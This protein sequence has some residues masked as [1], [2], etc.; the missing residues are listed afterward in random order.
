ME[1]DSYIYKHEDCCKDDWEYSI[2]GH[3][4]ADWSTYYICLLDISSKLVCQCSSYLWHLWIICTIIRKLRHLE[5]DLVC[6]WNSLNWDTCFAD[7]CRLCNNRN[8]IWLSLA[9]WVLFVKTYCKACTACKLN[10]E[11]KWWTLWLIVNRH[12]T[13]ACDYHDEWSEHTELACFH[14]VCLLWLS[15]NTEILGICNTEIHKRCEQWLADCQSCKYWENNTDSQCDRKSL[16]STCSEY[17]KYKS[18]DKRCNVTIYDGWQGIVETTLYRLFYGL[19]IRQLL[20]DTCE[21]DYIGINRHTYWQDNTGYTRKCQCYVEQ[22]DNQQIKYCIECQ[23]KWSHKTRNPEYYDHDKKYKCNTDRTCL[24]ACADGIWS[25]CST[26]Y[27]GTNLLKCKR[28]CTDT[29]SSSKLLGL[30]VASNLVDFCASACYGWLYCWCTYD[31]VV[32]YNV[33]YFSNIC[34]GNISE[35]LSSLIGECKLYHIVIAVIWVNSGCGILDVISCKSSLILLSLWPLC[36]VVRIKELKLSLNIQSLKYLIRIGNSRYLCCDLLISILVYWVLIGICLNSFLNLILGILEIFVTV[37]VFLN[38]VSYTQT[39]FKVK[40][41]LDVLNFTSVRNTEYR[42]IYSNTQYKQKGYDDEHSISLCFLHRLL[43]LPF[44]F[45]LRQQ[46]VCIPQQL[47]FSSFHLCR[48]SMHSPLHR[49]LSYPQHL[50]CFR[51]LH[52]FHQLHQPWLPWAWS[53]T[54]YASSEAHSLYHTHQVYFHGICMSWLHIRH[55]SRI[56]QNSLYTYLLHIHCRVWI[57]WLYP[58]SWFRQIRCLCRSHPRL[59]TGDT[60]TDLP[61]E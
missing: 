37:I 48:K 59:Q 55:C 46:T 44:L 33:Y 56:L 1:S 11:V 38:L 6:S 15:C 58:D 50:I 25:K 54:L 35:L 34:R 16:D 2:L 42:C 14:E 26:Y 36:V 53:H 21:Y 57:H 45:P 52:Q 13:E 10:T 29:D 39:S 51:Q 40:S 17:S 20:F 3:L 19:A 22:V 27:I 12:H 49:L 5:H 9:K 60:D 8:Y 41:K 18:C 4:A 61:K 30:L 7:T 31:L 47:L 24:K 23:G 32:I 28:K 43:L